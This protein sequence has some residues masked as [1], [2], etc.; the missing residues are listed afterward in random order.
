MDAVLYSPSRHQL[1]TED[2][3]LTF[4]ENEVG[5]ADFQNNWPKFKANQG[6][7]AALRRRVRS[8]L[9]YVGIEY[10]AQAIIDYLDSKVGKIAGTWR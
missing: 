7:D 5:R 9:A 8:W 6:D 10:D 2:I 3:A 1:D 4:V